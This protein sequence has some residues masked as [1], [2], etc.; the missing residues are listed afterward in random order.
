MSEYEYV[1]QDC[2]VVLNI[3]VP[4]H[5]K[6]SNCICPYCQGILRYTGMTI[7]N[8]PVIKNNV[9][10]LADYRLRKHGI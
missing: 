7:A 6:G 4:T 3:E 8:E 5:R 10:H 1:C 9:T 2:E